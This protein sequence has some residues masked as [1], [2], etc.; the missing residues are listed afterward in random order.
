[1]ETWGMLSLAALA[2]LI[3]VLWL[4]RRRTGTAASNEASDRLD[5]VAAW[6]PT[7]TRVLT[8]AER[9]AYALVLRAMPGHMILA[10]VP[11]AR[12]LR[13]PTRHS[14]S[15]W[16]RRLGS[17]CADLVVCDMSSEV[18][19]V[20]AIHP[21]PSK[22]SERARRRHKRMSRVLKS[23]QI[24]FFVWTE[25]GLPSAEAAR[26]QLLPRAAPAEPPPLP[27]PA[28]APSSQ[29]ATF[30]EFEN[31]LDHPGTAEPPPSTWFDEFNTAPMPL[32]PP[33]RR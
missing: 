27:Q 30:D 10:Q 26:D 19:A 2:V 13:V 28:V 16:L 4:M 18:L 22:M 9:Q 7:A 25:G 33:P 1:M 15:E 14:Y 17:Q 29:P 31:A 8:T 32:Q 3:V 24:P 20:L 5:T 12:F 6:P 11:L 23:A 21:E